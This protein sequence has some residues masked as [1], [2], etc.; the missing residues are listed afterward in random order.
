MGGF[1]EDDHTGP[2]TEL[3]LTEILLWVEQD[4]ANR[5]SLIAHAAPRTLDD[6]KGG[7]LTR[8]LLTRYPTIEGVGSG[9]SAIF[10]SG[11]HTGPTSAYLKRRRDKFRSWLAS[12]FSPEV[13]QWIERELDYLDKEIERANIEEERDRFA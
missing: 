1:D 11:G 13:I 5:A 3:P 9:I 8:E 10:H 12:G 4:P 2:I 7:G 6:D